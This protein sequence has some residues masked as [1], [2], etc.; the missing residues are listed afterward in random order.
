ME[1]SQAGEG[2]TAT[3]QE[4]LWGKDKAVRLAKE[5]TGVSLCH[6]QAS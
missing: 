3:D 4:D 1:F 5:L 2:I 6:Y